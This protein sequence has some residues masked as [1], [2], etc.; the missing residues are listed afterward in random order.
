M[1]SLFTT[2]KVWTSDIPY[3]KMLFAEDGMPLP[4][5]KDLMRGIVAVN[6]KDEPVGFI[7]ILQAKDEKDSF[8]NG[9]YVYPVIVFKNWQGHGVGRTLIETAYEKYGTLKLVA[10]K[11]SQKF[12]PKCG[13]KTLEWGEVAHIIENDCKEC[14][15]L[16][17]CN[18][19]PYILH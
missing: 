6:S 5:K 3:L 1:G 9:N 8:K 12:Y 16:A 11:A 2:R 18:P 14:P 15:D 4:P 10:C 13:F 17:T 7:R 19:Q